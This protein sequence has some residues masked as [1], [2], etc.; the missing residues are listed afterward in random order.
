[1]IIKVKDLEIGNK[2]LVPAGNKFKTLIV[3][4]KPEVKENHNGK[5]YYRSVRCS[6]NVEIKSKLSYHW[7]Y[8]SQSQVPHTYT[9][10]ECTHTF[11]N[12]N[13]RISVDLNYKDIYLI[14]EKDTE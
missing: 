11:D 2:I 6:I 14:T 5:D 13:T 1:M 4:K 7:D 8:K 3:V 10:K 9:W 12:H